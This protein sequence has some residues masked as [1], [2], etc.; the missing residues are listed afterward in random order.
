MSSVTEQPPRR[1]WRTLGAGL[2]GALA[3]LGVLGA[4]GAYYVPGILDRIGAKATDRVPIEVDVLGDQTSTPNYVFATTVDP[5]AVPAG[6]F[7]DPTRLAESR[8]WA[9]DNGGV[10]ADE[11]R[12]R[13]V[14]RGRDDR[15]VHLNEIRIRIQER[16][17]PRSGWANL[18]S[19]CGAAVEPRL[20]TF[21]VDTG[22]PA[23][24][25]VDGVPAQRP[26]FTVTASDEETIDVELRSTNAEVRWVLEVAYSSSERDGVLIVDDKGRPFTL[27]AA[28]NAV[29][30][31]VPVG[32][33]P[34]RSAAQIG[35]PD[36][37]RPLC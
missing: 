34:Q 33:R 26:A 18:W 36:V 20:L 32:G 31:E 29:L 30:Y 19:G 9:T 12:V 6:L 15:I 1:R 24:W 11:Q 13:F 22:A 27:T 10:I 16:R 37:T 35:D 21:N 23:Q 2:V 4:V 14:V 25:Q 7:D 17:A 28:S 3:T 5:S 8:R